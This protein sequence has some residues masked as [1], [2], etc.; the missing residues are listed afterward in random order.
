MRLNSNSN[1]CPSPTLL[2][3]LAKPENLANG[4]FQP[5]FPE[6]LLAIAK[7]LDRLRKRLTPPKRKRGEVGP[8]PRLGWVVCAQGPEPLMRCT[9][10]SGWHKARPDADI[11]CAIMRPNYDTRRLVV[12]EATLHRGVIRLTRRSR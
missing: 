11:T 1:R 12:R 7:E 3:E 10:L 8:A 9:V 2:R 5:I 6:T 4:R